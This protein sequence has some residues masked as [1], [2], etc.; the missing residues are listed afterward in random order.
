MNLKEVLTY[1]PLNFLTKG[2][3]RK[4]KVLSSEETIKFIIE[5]KVSISRYG[6][7]EIR[8]MQGFDLNFQ[9]QSK[10]LTRKLKEIKST[11]NCLLCI[12]NIFEKKFFSKKIIKDEE[13]VFWAKHLMKYEYLYKKK[14]GKVAPLGDAFISRFYI[15]YNDKSKQKNEKYITLLKQIWEQRD[16]VF[17]EGVNSRLG[18]GNDLFNNSRSIKRILCPPSDAFSVYDE[19]LSCVKSNC[20]KSDLI[21][22]A[23]GPTATVLAYDLSEMGYQAL[24]MGHVD[25]EYEWFLLGV[26]EKVAIP[27]KHVN[28]CDSMGDT[29]SS[30]LLQEYKNQVIAEIN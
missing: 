9:P 18:Y 1:V 26:K 29:E 5:H 22:L 23:L 7:G 16:I 30:Q 25:I 8:S 6:D 11:Q 20:K 3:Y 2:F 27:H 24:D 4:P 12:P 28:E 14:F 13:Y 21:I 17:V 10:E 19:I 15:R